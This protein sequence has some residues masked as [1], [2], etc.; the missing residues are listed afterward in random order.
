MKYKSLTPAMLMAFILSTLGAIVNISNP[1]MQGIAINVKMGAFLL[2]LVLCFCILYPIVKLLNF[3]ANIYDSA[4]DE[5]GKR[6]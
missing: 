5:D 2:S 4:V 6:C 3:L 1:A